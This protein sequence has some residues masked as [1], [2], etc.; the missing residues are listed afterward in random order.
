[1][2]TMHRP[3]INGEFTRH[4]GTQKETKMNR[5]NKL[6]VTR[7]IA[8]IPGVGFYAKLRITD[9]SRVSGLE[10]DGCASRCHIEGQRPQ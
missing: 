3:L 8:A 7:L 10:R 9:S 5:M 1:M 4:D 2:R 6:L